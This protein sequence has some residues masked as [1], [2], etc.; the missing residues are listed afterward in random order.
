MRYYHCVNCGHYHDL[1]EERQRGIVCYECGYD[2]PMEMDQEEWDE[3]VK[4][5]PWVGVGKTYEE[6]TGNKSTHLN[7][8]ERSKLDEIELDEYKNSSY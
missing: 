7:K 2:E 3:C 1:K 5:R 8:K 4:I 6:Y